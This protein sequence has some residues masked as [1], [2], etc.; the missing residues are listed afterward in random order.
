MFRI[1]DGFR[2]RCALN[3]R[4]WFGSV[5]QTD[6]NRPACILRN[7]RVAVNTTR[8]RAVGV[9]NLEV[10][11]VE[12][13]DRIQS[14]RPGSDKGFMATQLRRFAVCSTKDDFDFDETAM[15]VFVPENEPMKSET[16]NIWQNPI[17]FDSL[18]MFPNQFVTATDDEWETFD[19]ISSGRTFRTAIRIQFQLTSIKTMR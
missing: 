15:F 8:T 13:S 9:V 6:F 5:P 1:G 10:K 7:K 19:F 2:F 14:N 12:A 3:G 16:V 18:R 17:R 11:S 4:N